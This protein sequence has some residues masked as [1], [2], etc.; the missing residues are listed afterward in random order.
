M[1]R[2]LTFRARHGRHP[3]GSPVLSVDPFLG[4]H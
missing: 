4:D 2:T 1:T 3:A